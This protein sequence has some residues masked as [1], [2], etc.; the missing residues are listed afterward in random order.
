MNIQ[1]LK[2]G[3]PAFDLISDGGLPAGRTTLLAG[4]SGS[5]KTLFGAQFLAMGILLYDQPGVFVTFE[6][7][8]D[9][10]RKDLQ[11]FG[12]EIE[13]W[14]AEGKW[15]FIDA[16][17]KEEDIITI[18]EFDLSAFRIRLELAINKINAQRVV[19]D[20]IGS[21]F[22]HF[23]EHNIIRRE[24][25]K[26]SMTLRRLKVTAIITTERSEE[27]G[28]ISRYG[29][30]EFLTDNVIILRNVLANERRR[31]TLEILK[32]RGS[33]HVKGE[34]PFTIIPMKA[35][36][37]VPISAM[38][39]NQKASSERLYSG[40]PKLDD[41]CGGGFFKNSIVLV[42][43]ATGTGKTLLVANFLNGVKQKQE[44][45]LL[46]AFEESKE[47]LFRNAKTWG[48]DLAQLEAEGYL[49]V[50][51]LYPEVSSLEDHLINIQ[52]LV[53]AFK[54]DRVAIDSISALTRN[55][56]ERGFQEFVVALS[57]FL[58]HEQVTSMFTAT[59]HMLTGDASVPEGNIASITDAIILLRYVEMMGEMQ[60]SI[61][62]LKMRGSNHESSI[63]RLTINQTGMQIGEPFTGISGIL[64]N[65][66]KVTK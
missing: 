53:V 31:R 56:S 2:T 36:M 10:I 29:V 3:I 4:S 63:R 15:K 41:M 16:S 46:L 45:A 28:P 12:W 8:V 50:V 49:K 52:E 27:Y 44:R 51:C 38:T 40:L 59:T 42:S 30:E 57:N 5:A 25:S 43:G 54:P 66:P 55:P 17:A 6:E 14:E 18:G 60:R 20:S 65:N 1:K 62:V 64:S 26:V 61:M 21:I 39:L 35:I 47:Q 37:I 32:F 19:I 48:M 22:T 7:Q 13:K 33:S 23:P 9:D 11:S 58:K 24:M 34:N